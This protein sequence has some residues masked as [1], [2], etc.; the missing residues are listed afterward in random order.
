MASFFFP[1][2]FSSP[3]A[4]LFQRLTLLALLRGHCVEGC[5]PLLHVL[6]FAV[7]ADNLALLMLR[8]C[9]DFENSFLQAWQR[10]LYWGIAP[11]PSRTLVHEDPR[12]PSCWRQ[13]A[14]FC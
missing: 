1:R 3:H 5:P 11:S 12:R 13:L 10:K 7:R 9:Q 8:E 2:S 6:A 14:L 4:K